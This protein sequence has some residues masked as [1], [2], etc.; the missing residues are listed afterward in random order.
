MIVYYKPG[1]LKVTFYKNKKYMKFK[2]FKFGI[3]LKDIKEAHK[4]ALRIL[5]D[6]DSYCYIADT[7]EVT[8]V[9]SKKIIEWWSKE[10]VP[11]LERSGIKAIATVVPSDV[12][13]SYS[14]NDWQEAVIGNITLKNVKTL[15]EAEAFLTKLR[16]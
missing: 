8:G 7:S 16:L 11:K 14:T 2:W 4:K 9:L 3:S 6:N 13:A 5:L 10:W 15:K 12:M 1:F